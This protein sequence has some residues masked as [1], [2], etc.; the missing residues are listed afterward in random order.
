MRQRKKIKTYLMVVVMAA[1][2]VG[3][4]LKIAGAT[5]DPEVLKTSKAPEVQ[6]VS[7]DFSG[8]AESVSPAVVNV[9]TEKRVKNVGMPFHQFDKNPF[10]GDERFKDFFEPFFRLMFY[11]HRTSACR[12]VVEIV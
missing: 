5:K 12:R 1:F 3:A 9:Q 11:S 4:I 7:P 6:M 2:V 8:L 10:G